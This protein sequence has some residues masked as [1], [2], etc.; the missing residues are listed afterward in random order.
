MDEFVYT[1][2]RMGAE[3]VAWSPD[4]KR[5]ATSGF[6]DG[7]DGGVHVWDADTGEIIFRYPG[8]NPPIEWSHDGRWIAADNQGRLVVFDAANGQNRATYRAQIGH[9]RKTHAISWSPNGNLVASAGGD[10]IIEV[11]ESA[12]GR[13]VFTFRGHASNRVEAL[14]WSPDGRQIASGDLSGKIF[15]WNAQGGAF[16]PN[17]GN[18]Y[19]GHVHSVLALAWSPDGQY[20]ASAGG[21]TTTISGDNSLQVWNAANSTRLMFAGNHIGPVYAVAWSPDGRWIATSSFDA[22]VQVL[23][24]RNGRQVYTYREHRGPVLALAWSPD[25]QRIVSASTGRTGDVRVW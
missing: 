14:A 16:L 18:E 5:I 25:S 24:A 9:L 23:D 4:G 17:A 22:T 19:R 15:L 20:V 21:L 12:T 2:H 1:G 6:G 10:G 13:P 7:N 3:A 8:A 11:W